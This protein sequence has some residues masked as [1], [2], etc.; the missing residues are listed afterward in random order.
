MRIL[1]DNSAPIGIKRFLTGHEVTDTVSVGLA[2]A[3]N[4]D[5]LQAA[6]GTMRECQ[7]FCV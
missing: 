2:A 5:L 1:L 7:D 4:G 6:E 3:R